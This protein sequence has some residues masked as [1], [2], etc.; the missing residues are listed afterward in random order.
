MPTVS[1]ARRKQADAAA[2]AFDA[3]FRKEYGD[4]WD[5][6]H[7]YLRRPTAYAALINAYAPAA[8]ADSVL[9]ADPASSNY[10]LFK[11]PALESP[12]PTRLLSLVC[13]RLPP[14]RDLPFPPA[15]PAAASDPALRLHTHWNLDAASILV[16]HMLDARPGH[17]V[18][19]LCSAPGGKAICI[20]QRLWPELYADRPGP[21]PVQPSM[22]HVNEVDQSRN[23]RLA[24][25]MK[26][27]LPQSLFD[28]GLVEVLQLDGS[29]S[30]A[31]NLFP[32]G[33]EGYDRVL[34]DAPCSSERHI[35]H[36][37]TR[38]SNSGTIA[39]EMSAWKPQSSKSI[40]KLQ[41]SLLRTAW[42]ALRVGGKM[43]YA[44]CSLSSTENDQ[45]VAAFLEGND[46]AV[47]HWG[48]P[49]P[50]EDV[51]LA[52][53]CE[54]TKFGRIALPD[55]PIPGTEQRS[56]WGPLYFCMLHKVTTTAGASGS[57]NH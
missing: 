25:N 11:L 46:S 40:A 20:A 18:L 23:V 7:E 6:L 21:K 56:P 39:P 17:A 22:L 45:V 32:L 41:L 13:P 4:R 38:A 10:A 2:A 31:V 15:R 53:A 27:F 16:A 48:V 36:A 28:K 54:R 47:V 50:A 44:T 43:I 30:R 55:H 35:I 34:L 19:D 9:M 37:H 42:S 14:G 49:G 52:A 3:H 57:G 26:N 24:S 12:G 5:T 8:E 1:K 51:Q 33:E 29:S